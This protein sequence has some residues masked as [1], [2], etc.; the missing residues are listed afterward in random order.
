ML[1]GAVSKCCNAAYEVTQ[2]R[3]LQSWRNRFSDT[4]DLEAWTLPIW[5][6]FQKLMRVNHIPSFCVSQGAAAL[7]FSLCYLFSKI[8]DVVVVV[9]MRECLKS[10]HMTIFTRISPTPAFAHMKNC[11]QG[12][13][14]NFRTVAHNILC[15]F[16][17]SRL[18][19]QCSGWRRWPNFAQLKLHQPSN[20][21]LH[22]SINARSMPVQW[23]AAR[24]RFCREQAASINRLMPSSTNQ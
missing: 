6:Q 7:P 23:L 5:N 14:T 15:D 13:T 22:Q 2:A 21:K 20:A 18:P 3:D 8:C 11:W 1:I 17:V 9:S 10:F 16:I 4:L 19:C 24:A 12:K